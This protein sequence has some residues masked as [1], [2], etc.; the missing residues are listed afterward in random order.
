ME[1]DAILAAL[2]EN[3]SRKFPRDAVKQA[4]A[5]KEEMTPLLLAAI[6]EAKNNLAELA[7]KPSYFL[8]I[9][10]F[11]LLAQFRE[12]KAYPLIVEFCSTPG[13]I[14]YDILG[15][16]V[17][18]DL[19]RIL[20]SVYDGDLSPIKRLIEDPSVNESVSIAALGA[21]E[22]LVAQNVLSRESVLAYIK[23]LFST[24]QQEKDYY[25]LSSLVIVST[26]LCPD[27]ELL[28]IIRSV[29]EK[30]SVDEM[31][32]LPEEVE[33]A[34]QIG[35]DAALAELRTKRHYRFVEN[36]IA[37]MEWWACFR[38][39]EIKQ[40]NRTASSPFWDPDVGR[41][42]KPAAKRK[43]KRQMQKQSRKQNRGKKKK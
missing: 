26:E 41:Y 16:T 42:K 39:D 22:T 19:G 1:L 33:E 3:T 23:E 8:H 7:N 6:E 35:P 37:E 11:F 4:I 28:T 36:A 5:R 27:E 34:L 18:E 14:V 24:Q 21:L 20:A 9:Y 12:T 31:L 15:D 38:E 2:E 30:G 29:F 17:T 43:K 40:A 10:A 32:I 13:E 25:F